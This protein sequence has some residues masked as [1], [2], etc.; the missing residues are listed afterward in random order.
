LGKVSC[1][2]PRLN[3]VADLY[4]FVQIAVMNWTLGNIPDVCARLQKDHFTCPN[5][6]A[7]F[8]NSITWGVIGPQRMFGP[9]SIYHFVHWYWLL[10]ALLPVLF[11]I[12]MRFAPRSPARFLNAP[13]MLGAMAW[14]PPATPLSFSTWAIFGLIFNFWIARRWPNW[15]HKYNYITAAGLDSGLILSTIVIFFAILFPNVTVPQWWGNVSV[16]ETTV[17]M[18]QFGWKRMIGCSTTYRTT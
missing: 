2:V 1:A 11:Y 7:F 12:L 13:V 8:S 16:F 9:G 17:S 3:L 14:L 5:G 4:S 15:W 10:G 18:A 6:R